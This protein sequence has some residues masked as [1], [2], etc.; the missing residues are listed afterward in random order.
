MAKNHIRTFAKLFTNLNPG[1]QREFERALNDYQ[2][3]QEI[4]N[5]NASL[6][7][8]R[9]KPNQLLAVPQLVLKSTI[10]GAIISWDLLPDQRISAYEVEVS[11]TANFAS[12]FTLS[13][14]GNSIVLDGL[15]GTTFVRVRGI[16]TDGTQGPRSDVGAIA[17]QL[18]SVKVRTDE[19]FYVAIP[20]VDTVTIIGGAGSVF[21]YQPINPDG[22]SMVWGFVSLYANPEVA[23]TGTSGISMRLE[24]KVLPANTN[25]TIWAD[26]AADYFGSY[27]IGPAAVPHPPLNETL[28]LRL[29]VRDIIPNNK[30]YVTTVL[31]AHMSA[32]ELGVSE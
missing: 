15:T 2:N 22:F 7:F 13:T 17:P 28:Q 4:T 26:T 1:Q 24:A 14:F 5:L 12:S 8:L 30:F 3:T 9:R 10:R 21:E 25:V 20:D 11:E 29:D 16:R 32:L 23:I 19:V 18:F 31:W 27:Q 6:E